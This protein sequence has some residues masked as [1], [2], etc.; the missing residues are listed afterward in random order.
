MEFA[1]TLQEKGCLRLAF[2][3]PLVNQEALPGLEKLDDQ[4][5]NAEKIDKEFDGLAVCLHQ[6]FID[7]TVLENV[8]RA[9]VRVFN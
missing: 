9:F 8:R 2:Y 3:D 5:W 4:C 7:F 6:T 1:R